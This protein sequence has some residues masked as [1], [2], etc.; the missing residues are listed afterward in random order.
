MK[1][2]KEEA[3]ELV[4]ILHP[5]TDFDGPKS[6][7]QRVLEK[8]QDR[9]TDYLVNDDEECCDHEEEEGDDAEAEDEYEDEEDSSE[10]GDEEDDEDEDEGKESSEEDDDD[11][12][13]DEEDSAD[14]TVYGDELHALKACTTSDGALEFEHV[15]DEDGEEEDQVDLLLDG[16]V[17]VE[18]VVRIRRKGKELYVYD[19]EGSSHQFDVS[20]FPK[21]WADLLPIGDL[22]EVEA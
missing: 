2:S 18:K 14:I 9:L 11:D 8:I 15:I 16:A 6:S 20:K 19:D 3:L 22:A 5:H 1:I 17:Y 13:E 21:G 4:K 10:E 12:S 7:H